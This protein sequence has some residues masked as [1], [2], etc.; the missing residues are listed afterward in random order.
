MDYVETYISAFR[1]APITCFVT[2]TSVSLLG[3]ILDTQPQSADIEHRSNRSKLFST[4]MGYM[5]TLGGAGALLYTAYHIYAHKNLPD[6]PVI[7]SAAA[8]GL[9]RFVS[10]AFASIFALKYRGNTNNS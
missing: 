5:F 3:T 1:E 7:L 8:A 4:L 6:N 2:F 10:T 9:S